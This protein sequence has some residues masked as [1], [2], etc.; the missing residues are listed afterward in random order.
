V[1]PSNH[2]HLEAARGWLELGDLESAIEE[3]DQMTPE[4]Q[5]HP[6]AL[7]TRCHVHAKA[8]QWDHVLA[9][10]E[11][12]IR[13]APDLRRGWIQRSYA[14]HEMN[15]TQEAL[16]ALLP[17]AERFPKFWM[18]PYN[19]ACYCSSLGKLPDAWSWLQKAFDLAGVPRLKTIALEDRDLEPLWERIQEL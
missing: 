11:T 12:L 16:Q 7:L 5:E 9:L 10:G 1:E 13:T 18:I 3:L 8:R 15:R 4:A 14:L 17:A 6:D 2:F 19:L